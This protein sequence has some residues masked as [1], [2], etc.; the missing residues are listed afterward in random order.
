MKNKKVPK[1]IFFT[2]PSFICL[3]VL[4]KAIQVYAY[5]PVHMLVMNYSIVIIASKHNLIN[6]IAKERR[7]LYNIRQLIIHPNHQS[8][9]TVCV[10]VL[11]DTMDLS[12]Y[13]DDW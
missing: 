5:R 12:M 3:T 10:S 4:V 6:N 1:I 2:T 7:Y 11:F 8:V 13:D 9:I